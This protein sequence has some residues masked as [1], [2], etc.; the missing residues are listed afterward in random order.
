MKWDIAVNASFS[1]KDSK[2]TPWTRNKFW[3]DSVEVMNTTSGASYYLNLP[4]N[5]FRDENGWVDQSQYYFS[6]TAKES[7][8]ATTGVSLSFYPV[9]DFKSSTNKTSSTNVRVNTGL[10]IDLIKGLKYEGRI[11]YSRIHSKTEQ[12]RTSN[13][14]LVR[15]ER[16]QTF[17]PNTNKHRVPLS[18]G[19]YKLLNSEITD[20]TLRNQLNY[21]RELQE[22]K[23]QITAIAG[24]EIRSY[25]NTGYKN[26]L[27]GY[28]MQTMQAQLYDAY[29]LSNTVSPVLFGRYAQINVKSYT[30]T[31][32]AKKY[33]SLYANAAYT[34]KHKYTANASIRVDQ[35]NL[36]GSDPSNQYKPI[37][38]IGAA[39]KI[40]DETFMK[41]I[42]WLN[43]LKLRGSFGFAGNSP[44]PGTGGRYD[45]LEATTS[46]TFETQG[47]NIITPAN[48][49]LTWEKTRTIN[50]GFDIRLLNNRVNL[51]LDYYDK[52]TQDLIGS[53]KL[54]P[55]TGWL[56]TTGNLGE[57]TNKGF[58]LS[59]NA[60]MCRNKNFS[61]NTIL[62][63]SKNKNLVKKIEVESPISTATEL[64]N[65]SFVEG[66]PVGAIF[67]YRY[68]GLD[69]EGY[70]QAYDKDGNIVTK[71]STK[72]MKSED[73]VFSGTTVPKVYG[74][75]TNRFQY[76]DFEFS[77]MFAY[78]FG[79]KMRDD[80]LYFFGR[81]G[82][83]LLKEYDKRWRQP[84]DE[85]F[86]D[87]PKYTIRFDNTLNPSVYYYADTHVC[88]ASYIRLRELTLSYTVP[89]PFCRKIG[90]AGVK[91][92]G[93]VGNL[94]LIAF[95]NK[96]IDPE[97]YSYSL[98]TY[99]ARLQKYGPSYS[100]NV[101]V[102]F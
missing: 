85:E 98:G 87:I 49:K 2:L 78:K 75:L 14:Y 10:T 52:F 71:S 86:T 45:I 20:W 47:Y 8:E 94:F 35:S 99:D 28:D 26:L 73:L 44:E 53:M 25:C 36:F 76:K 91:L 66:Y 69:N 68:A 3:D 12:Y 79:A 37:W 39:W 102:N 56:S 30:Q 29:S 34:Y 18:G 58:E 80:G 62:T 72:N 93:Q 46:T 92:T 57:L 17:N 95:N 55:T 74:A 61:W 64:M 9:S 59:I 84:G 65:T 101:N 6:S 23:H 50:L 67:S 16:V 21:D 81:P 22:G 27:R 70:P 33:F 43:E 42:D 51:S 1:N 32:A 13:S 77:F 82:A 90:V 88:D 83:N 31:E 19:H 54:N 11:Q 40:S 7:A 97:A 5:I 96:G 41:D 4:Y 89:S 100:F 24:T 15:E 60:T 63:L 48:D 38:S